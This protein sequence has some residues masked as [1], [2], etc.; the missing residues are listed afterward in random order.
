MP[1][2]KEIRTQINSI[3]STRRIIKAM[4]LKAAMDDFKKN[5]SW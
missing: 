4:K 3:G 1:G 5:G 2:A